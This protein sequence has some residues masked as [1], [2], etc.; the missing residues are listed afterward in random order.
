M[1]ATSLFEADR[2]TLEEAIE[3]TAAS[4]REYGARHRHWRF[5]FSGGKD[6][7]ATVT[8]AAHLIESGRVPRPESIGVIYADTRMELPPLQAAAMGV[9]AELERRGWGV[10]VVKPEID[11]RFFVKM[12]GVGV[13]PSHSGFRWCTG[14]LKVEPMALAMREVREQTGEKLLMATGMRIGESAARDRRI[15]LSCGKNGGECGQGWY[16]EATPG[17]VADTLAPLLHWRVCHVADWLLFEAPSLGFP[18]GPIV[19]AYGAGAGDTE[20]LEARTGCLVC[21]VASRDTV[22][23]RVVREP[24][25][26]YLKPLLRLRAL[27]EDLA[28]AQHRLRKQ[29]E[30]RADGTLGP[31][32]MRLGPL[33]FEARRYGLGRVLEIQRA[34]DDAAAALGRPL[35]NL[36]DAEEQARIDEL[37]AAETWPQGWLGD[38]VR[39]DVLVPM[40]VAEGVTQALLM[41]EGA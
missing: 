21:P 36:I 12:F 28:G 7:G 26:A 1:R 19:E 8:I 17:E 38:E 27:Y 33:T 34:V 20:P 24:T 29:G 23:E 39:G 13:P 3:I 40:V 22:L 9:L 35:V 31:R 25:W 4:L 6:S 10:Q 14:M 11:H 30:R 41:A 2:L 5:A 16:Q 37:I 18:T 32:P 15:A